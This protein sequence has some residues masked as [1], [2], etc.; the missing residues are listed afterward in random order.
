V[1]LEIR[2]VPPVVGRP[3]MER[4][5]KEGFRVSGQLFSGAV[6]LLPDGAVEWPVT[7]IVEVT[8]ESLAPVT[9]RSDVEILLLGTG[10][11]MAPVPAALRQAL[12]RHGIGL[13]PMDTGAACRTYSVLVSEDRRVAAALLKI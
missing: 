11:R 3:V 1:T 10:A 9:A 2:Q 4:Y 5:G 12:R 13:E 6:L 7:S 8:E